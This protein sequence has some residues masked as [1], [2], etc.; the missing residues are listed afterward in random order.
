MFFVVDLG[1]K[2]VIDQNQEQKTNWKK[3]KEIRDFLPLFHLTSSR[4]GLSLCPTGCVS[5][6]K[7]L[8]SDTRL[9]CMGFKMVQKL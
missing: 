5:W 4:K 9:Q 7:M 3:K 2:E 8:K 6:C 1:K